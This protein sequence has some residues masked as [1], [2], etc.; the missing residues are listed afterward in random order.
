M[1]KRARDIDQGDRV[2]FNVWG[3]RERGERSPRVLG[4]GEEIRGAS[5][6]CVGAGTLQAGLWRW[7]VLL[8]EVHC[9]QGSVLGTGRRVGAQLQGR[10][11]QLWMCC[12]RS[13]N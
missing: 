9:G 1:E 12:R 8:G 5:I 11:S 3:R 10:A 7:E 6:G 4:E 2:G 13:Q